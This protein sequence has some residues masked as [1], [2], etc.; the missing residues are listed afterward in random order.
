MPRRLI[1]WRSRLLLRMVGGVKGGRCW[2][3]E[4][5]AGVEC[6]CRDV[7]AGCQ[8]GTPPLSQRLGP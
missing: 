1:R 7:P 3:V 4:A 8:E 5:F 6:R 2:A